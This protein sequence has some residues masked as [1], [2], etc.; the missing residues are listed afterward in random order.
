MQV[1]GRNDGFNQPRTQ[2]FGK[3]LQVVSFR[4][5]SVFRRESQREAVRLDARDPAVEPADMIDIG[6]HALTE[7][8][9]PAGGKGNA[10]RRH[11]GNPARKF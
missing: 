3:G 8:P 1:T 6:D 10:S 9:G 11:V 5:A 7:P 2:L 4:A